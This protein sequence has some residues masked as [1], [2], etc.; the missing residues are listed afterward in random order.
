MIVL[1]TC[2]VSAPGNASS[3]NKGHIVLSYRDT[4]AFCYPDLECRYARL[5]KLQYAQE[6][7][8]ADSDSVALEWGQ[9]YCISPALRSADPAGLRSTP[10]GASRY[11]TKTQQAQ[12]NPR[13]G[14]SK[15]PHRLMNLQFIR[16]LPG[17]NSQISRGMG[18]CS[19]GNVSTCP[20]ATKGYALWVLL[21]HP[22]VLSG[23]GCKDKTMASV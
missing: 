5:V 1:R 16:N 18:P 14:I 3:L 10:W 19:M 23:R 2:S 6:P 22:L 8:N 20:E 7:W 13:A 4:C 11:A 15:N 9:R 21:K 12:E 17:N